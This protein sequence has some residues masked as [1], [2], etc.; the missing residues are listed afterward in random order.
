MR[1]GFGIL[2]LAAALVPVSSASAQD[3]N[4]RR[5]AC[6]QKLGGKTW[7]PLI[8]RA[9]ALRKW[10]QEDPRSPLQKRR[11]KQHR[12]C[13]RTPETREWM[14]RSARRHRRRFKDHRKAEL[15]ARR[16]DCIPGVTVYEGG[17]GCWAIPAD[18]VACE[19]GYSW[20]AYNGSSGARGPYQFLGSAGPV[21]RRLD[22]RQAGASPD[23][24]EALRRRS[25]AR[26][27]G[28]L[29]M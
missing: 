10:R 3:T 17:G 28:L 15:A 1:K 24:G 18:I 23:G 25:G 13:A 9:W 5:P 6:G 22:R 26:P 12:R 27:L 8:D 4:E 29:T 11:I 21:A 2:L 14:I 19:S 7:K 20:S 16:S